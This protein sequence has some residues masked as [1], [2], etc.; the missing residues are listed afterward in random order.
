MPC[1]FFIL[2]KASF[3][4]TYYLTR[5]A[6]VLFLSALLASSGI[7]LSAL[8]LLFDPYGAVVLSLLFTPGFTRGY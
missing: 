8:G 3:F 6:P 5:L 1:H 7:L 4:R 2:F